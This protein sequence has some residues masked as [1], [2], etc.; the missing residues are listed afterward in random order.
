MSSDVDD[1]DL[2]DGLEDQSYEIKDE[3]KIRKTLEAHTD[4]HFEFTKND[5][6]AY[7][8]RITEW[9]RRPRSPDDNQTLGF[10]ELERSR[11]DKEHSWITGDIPESWKF[12]SFLMRKVRKWNRRNRRFD[13]L[14]DEFR[15]TVYLKFNHAMDNCFAASIADIHQNG[16]KTP[17]S[18]GTKD[19]TYLAL[20]LDD[21][22][23]RVGV[24]DCVSF[25]ESYLSNYQSGQRALVEWSDD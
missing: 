23:V 10:V 17:Y 16:Q 12:Y 3:L 15:R 8:L 6:Y 1:A 9:H 20:D 19:N 18:D 7:D 4:W 11:A 2:T 24:E 21:P 25:I 5:Q 22:A 14:K 13:G